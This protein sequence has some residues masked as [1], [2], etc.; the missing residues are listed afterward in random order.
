MFL[1]KIQSIVSSVCQ[2]ELRNCFMI[3]SMVLLQVNEPLRH[4]ISVLLCTDPS[5]KLPALKFHAISRCSSTCN[6]SCLEQQPGRWGHAA[7]F[8]PP[9]TGQNLCPSVLLPAYCW[10]ARPAVPQHRI[11]HLHCS[12]SP[13]SSLRYI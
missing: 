8:P 9:A 3:T 4:R 5:G 13:A 2:E 1:M 7:C 10:L 11:I 6:R 12:N